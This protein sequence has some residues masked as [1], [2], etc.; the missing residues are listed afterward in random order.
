MK[1]RP[2][3]PPSIADLER[4]RFELALEAAACGNARERSIIRAQLQWTDVALQDQLALTEVRRDL[5]AIWDVI[6]G[7]SAGFLAL[8]SARREDRALRAPT[9]AYFTWPDQVIEAATWSVAEAAAEREVYHCAHLLTERHRRK[10]FA[11]PLASLYIDLD[12]DMLPPPHLRPTV[13]VASSSGRYQGYFR[14][15]GTVNPAQGEELNRRLA[16]AIGADRSGWDLTQLLRVPGTRNHKYDTRPRVRVVEISGNRYDPNELHMLLP[17]LMKQHG[18]VE[19]PSD[20]STVLRS[21]QSTSRR[22]MASAREVWQGEA[23][24]RTLDGRIDRSASLVKIARLLSDAGAS[25]DAIAE[26]LA[27]RDV[28]LDWR[29]YAGR[30]DAAEQYRRIA[31][32]VARDES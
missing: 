18:P 12:T 6:F 32:L 3:P 27:E 2:F 11:A 24:K 20:T 22:L 30:A 15:T 19:Q 29:K 9:T 8:F 4:D 7:D 21:E 1:E 5:P 28:T 17:D 13:L 23:P 26:A 14:L 10:R 31:E 25:T 16:A